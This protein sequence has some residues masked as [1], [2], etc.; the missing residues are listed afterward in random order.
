MAR[1]LAPWVRGRV[2]AE[3]VKILGAG[4]SALGSTRKDLIVEKVM[5]RLSS[6][7]GDLSPSRITL[8]VREVSRETEQWAQ[9]TQKF[10][11]RLDIQ[12]NIEERDE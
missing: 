10:K 8:L 6:E 12:E 4:G 3:A 9:D 2:E 5:R 7:P 11:T 1:E